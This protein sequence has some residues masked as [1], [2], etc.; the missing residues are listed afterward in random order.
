MNLEKVKSFVYYGAEQYS[1]IALLRQMVPCYLFVTFLCVV[2]SLVGNIFAFGITSLS[3]TLIYSLIVYTFHLWCSKPSFSCRFATNA[4]GMIVLSLELQLM[5]YTILY[6]GKYI[7]FRDIVL[8]AC[9]QLISGV[10]CVLITVRKVRN[11]KYTNKKSGSSAVNNAVISGASFLG[12]FFARS[13]FRKTDISVS[14]AATIA[15]VSTALSVFFAI[16]A[17]FHILKYY[18]AKKYQITTD[19]SGGSV[20][21]MLVL[22]DNMKNSLVKK[23]WKAILWVLLLLIMCAVLYGMY[24]VSRGI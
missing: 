3:I 17:S 16:L 19:E 5:C 7:D 10:I 21:Q 13:L 11:G 14:I 18:Y 2:A 22:S 24:Q 6:A 20:S 15:A 4:F 8:I 12:Y 23:I 1:S 9:L